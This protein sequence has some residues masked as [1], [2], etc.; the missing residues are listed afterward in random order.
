MT[1]PRLLTSLATVALVLGLASQA[2]ADLITVTFSGDND[3]AGVFELGS[4]FDT[5]DVGG[6]LPQPEPISPIIVK[7][8]DDGQI[9]SLYSG[10]FTGPEITFG[11][12]EWW[13][14]PEIG[15]DP[16]VKFWSARGGDGFNLFWAVPDA[17]CSGYN[18]A[19]LGMALPQTHGTYSVPG[20]KDLSHLSFYNGGVTVPEP[21]TLVLLGTG[22]ALVGARYRRRKK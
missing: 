12:G 14:D 15:V 19:C 16:Q 22:L 10:I 7:Y 5:C 13:Y 6:N 11:D 8:G 21:S 18:A 17:A 20:G 9:N 1:T 3:C 4:G 2:K